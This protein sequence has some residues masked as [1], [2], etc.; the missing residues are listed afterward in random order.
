MF[1]AHKQCIRTIQNRAHTY[2]T[3]KWF[4]ETREASMKVQAFFRKNVWR[5]KWMRLR[6]GLRMVHSLARG[7]IVR[8]H[9]LKM[10]DAVLIIQDSSREFLGRNRAYWSKVHLALWLQSWCR[11]RVSREERE[12]VVAHLD[13]RRMYR[14]R[15]RA[16]R[17]V[18]AKWRHNGILQKACAQALVSGESTCASSYYSVSADSNSG[19]VRAVSSFIVWL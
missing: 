4:T 9:V 8:K 7:F 19:H 17:H 2:Q 12:D 14:K 11:G 15:H 16:V 13:R 5:L 3:R 10:L 18:Q 6:R 1:D